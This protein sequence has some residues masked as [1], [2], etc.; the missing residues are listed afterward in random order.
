MFSY[1]LCLMIEGSGSV[2]LTYGFG[3]VRP[4]N[5]WILMIRIRIIEELSTL[6]HGCDQQI[7]HSFF[8]V[9]GRI[10]ILTKNNGSEFG[11]PKNLRILRIRIWKTGTVEVWCVEP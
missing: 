11:K 8:L 6:R 2:S 3:Y 1:F 4:K 7:F 9:G 5:I 10:R